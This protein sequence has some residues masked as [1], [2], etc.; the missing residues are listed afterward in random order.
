MFP[1]SPC[2]LLPKFTDETCAGIW[3]F[4]KKLSDLGGGSWNELK[5]DGGSWKGGGGDGGMNGTGPGRIDGGDG[6]G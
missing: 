1:D 3:K 4:P 6:G 2:S 5:A